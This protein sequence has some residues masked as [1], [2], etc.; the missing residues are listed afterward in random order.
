M[1]PTG[2]QVARRPPGP[3]LPESVAWTVAYLIAQLL[4]LGLFLSL[5]VFAAFG[6]WN[7]DPTRVVDLLLDVELD[8]SFVPLG[9]ANLL[10]LFALVPAAR[11]RLGRAWRDRLGMELPDRRRLLLT[12]SAVLPLS[13]VSEQLYRWSLA[14]WG[15]LAQ[16]W[17]ET[18]GWQQSNAVDALL[19]FA[20]EESYPVLVVA[21]ALGPA[22]GEELVFRGVIGRGLVGRWGAA[23]GM[24]L[25]SLLFAMAHG[26]PPHALATVPIGLFLHHVYRTTGSLWT[27]IIVHF[28]NNL[29]I[30]S[31][32]RFSVV[33]QLPGSPLLLC[34]AL[35][36]VLAISL[37]L[38]QPSRSRPVDAPLRPMPLP[39]G[40]GGRIRT[41][42]AAIVVVFTAAFVWSAV[43]S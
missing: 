41:L 39:S 13:I 23:A 3:G 15:R 6:H 19:G 14:L 25:T 32:A 22:I 27:P 29:L 10:C 40:S 4:A 35:A 11:L 21:I 43:G 9:V 7:V 37:M 5:I 18:A 31:L 12:V 30:I 1:V 36:Y 28:L 8:R 24:V 42:A 16:V 34:S 2:V 17:P 38:T 26:F 20:R 33:E